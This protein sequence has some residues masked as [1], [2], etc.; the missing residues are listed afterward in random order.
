[1]PV[2]KSDVA[3]LVDV[4]LEYLTPEQARE[5]VLKMAERVYSNA[6]YRVTVMRLVEELARRRGPT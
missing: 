1:M 4:M 6:S 3:V 5:M 2:G